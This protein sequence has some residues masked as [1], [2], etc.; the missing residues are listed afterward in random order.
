MLPCELA[1]LLNVTPPTV[2]RW[3]TGVRM[4]DLITIMKIADILGIK[5]DDLLE[6][7]QSS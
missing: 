1:K 7:E 4:P 2:H 6:K 5:V 3:E